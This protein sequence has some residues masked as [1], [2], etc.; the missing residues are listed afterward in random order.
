MR[1][2]I[3]SQILSKLPNELIVIGVDNL[4][5]YWKQYNDLRRRNHDKAGKNLLI[6]MHLTGGLLD[7]DV[8]ANFK[9][10]DHV[11]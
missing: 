6:V 3:L 7:C 5:M 8:S 4:R 10:G 11:G 2:N 9:Q 1:L